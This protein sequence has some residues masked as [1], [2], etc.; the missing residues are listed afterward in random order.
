MAK[1]R[2]FIS[3]AREDRES[4]ERL[5][6]Y[7]DTI[8]GVLPWLDIRALLPGDNWARAIGE[9]L[10]ES[11]LVIL[12][13][14]NKSVSKAGYVQHEVRDAL[15]LFKRRPPDERFLIP[16]RIEFCLPKFEELGRLHW[17]DLFA[18]WDSG[19]ATLRKTILHEQARE[20]E[21]AKAD[22]AVQREKNHEDAQKI[23][24]V[25]PSDLKENL[26]GY[27][28]WLWRHDFAIYD[29]ESNRQNFPNW[30]KQAKLE[31]LQLLQEHGALGPG[32][33]V[34]AQ[35]TNVGLELL[36]LL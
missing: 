16:A 20:A 9:A 21:L 1:V 17:L 7:L 26:E 12:V 24:E 36:H 22:D 2:V 32:D 19:L 34:N 15:E 8:P 6:K 10:K 35:F 28:E 3:Y 14:S 33:G 27:A 5:Y 4:A 30:T 11:R 18:D 13:L 25:L 23:L 29:Y 31:W